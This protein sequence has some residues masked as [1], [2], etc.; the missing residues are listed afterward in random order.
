M[1]AHFHI[2]SKDMTTSNQRQRITKHPLFA[3]ETY[4]IY[5][6]IGISGLVH[7]L[8]FHTCVAKSAVF[9]QNWLLLAT[10]LYLNYVLKLCALH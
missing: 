7:N 3:K 10:L 1:C 6:L 8:I 9:L 5:F 4:C 2:P